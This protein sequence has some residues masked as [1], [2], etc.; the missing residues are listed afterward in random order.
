MKIGIAQI[1]PLKGDI[2]RNLDKHLKFINNAL[3]KQPD[4]LMFPELSLTGYEPEL[5]RS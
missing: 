4:L 2:E 3:E 5:A 1:K